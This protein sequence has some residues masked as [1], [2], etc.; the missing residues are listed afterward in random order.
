MSDFRVVIPARHASMR[1]PGKPLVKL[2]GVPMIRHVYER[3]SAS[4]AAEVLVATDDER[5]AAAARAFGAPV[6]MTRADHG[7]GTERVAEVA[8]ARGWQADAIVVNVQGD[9]PL[10]PSRSISQ[11]AALL[12]GH[13]TAAIATLCTRVETAEDYRNPNVV[14]VVMDRT[15]RALYFSRAPIPSAAHGATDMPEAWRHLGLYAYRV[16]GL[17]RLSSSPPCYIESVEKLEQLRALW[18]GMEIR[19][20]VAIEA[21]GPDVDI[22]ADVPVVERYLLSRPPG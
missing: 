9:S 15:G 11:V 22:P 16:D 20:A 8:R 17:E 5:I 12:D 13:P 10:M 21:P 2:A 1:F 3:A 18:L 19:V 6:V 7:S 4:G 14:K